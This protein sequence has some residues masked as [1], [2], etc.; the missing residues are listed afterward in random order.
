MKE[1]HRVQFADDQD[2]C[3]YKEYFKRYVI[4]KWLPEACS[5]F[6]SFFDLEL[7]FDSKL[8]FFN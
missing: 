7:L 3:V 6:E 4:F 8:F 5:R 2:E 1:P